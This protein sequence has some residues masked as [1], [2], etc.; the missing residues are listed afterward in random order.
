MTRRARHVLS[1]TP[2]K[3]SL[4]A[5]AFAAATLGALPARGDEPAAAA[6]R[7]SIAKEL[8][9]SIAATTLL[10]PAIYGTATLIANGDGDLNAAWLPAMIVAAGAPPAIATSGVLFERHREGAKAKFLPTYFFPF[11]AQV[12]VI[13]GAS[14]AKT[15]VGE[16][17]DLLVLS[18]VTGVAN[19]AAATLGAE[20]AF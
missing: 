17:K 13:V 19:G 11:I 18:L 7:P 9:V 20:L 12:A 6:P 14:F 2:M 3:R 5:L 16:T 4:A 8:A 1:S 15:F 10:A